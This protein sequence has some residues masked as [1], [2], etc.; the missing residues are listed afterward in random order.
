[1]YLIVQQGEQPLKTKTI[2]YEDMELSNKGDT[3]L[4][5]ITDP[6]HPKEFYTD[7]WLEVEDR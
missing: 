2:S 5:D 4:L 1:M 3:F 6:L 7:K